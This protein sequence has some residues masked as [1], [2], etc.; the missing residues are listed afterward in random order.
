MAAI[1]PPSTQRIFRFLSFYGRRFL[2]RLHDFLNRAF[3]LRI[4]AFGHEGRVIDYR[5]VRVHPVAFDDPFALG[6]ID[7]EAR[8]SYISSI[9]ERG[10]SSNADQSAPGAGA[11]NRSESRLLEIKR[12]A[13]SA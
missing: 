2:E 8:H 3:Q 4:A 11:N 7:A 1:L 10:S 6:A 5:N 9:H 12:E 13:I